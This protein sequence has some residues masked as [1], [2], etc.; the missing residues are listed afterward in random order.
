MWAEYGDKSPTSV[1]IQ[2]TVGD[3]MDSLNSNE[4]NIH[5]GKVEYKDYSN[6]H[7][8]PYQDLSDTVF[9]QSNDVLGLFYAPFL[10][11]EMYLGM[12]TKL[13]Q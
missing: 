11:S 4:Y 5:I 7:I 13:E 10:T 9:T 2:T 6:E 3:L 1:A 8:T 12:K